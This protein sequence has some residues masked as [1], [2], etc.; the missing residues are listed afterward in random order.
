MIIKLNSTVR[1]YVLGFAW[2]VVLTLTA[3]V[4][5]VNQLLSKNE[6]VAYILVLALMQVGVQ[7]YFFLHLGDES[8]PRWNLWT[9]LFM[10]AILLIIVVGSLWIMHN[11]NYNM[12]P[13]HEVDKYM[14]E[15][16]N[17]GF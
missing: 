3:Y 5:V 10:S 6:L 12:M 16:R 15:E 4:A 11:L 9:F 7:L 2:S 17:K 1:L 8:K 13:S 14:L